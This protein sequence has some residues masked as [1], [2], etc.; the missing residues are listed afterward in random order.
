MW[1]SYDKLPV[2]IRGQLFLCEKVVNMIFAIVHFL[3]LFITVALN[4]EKAWSSES[5][6]TV[7]TDSLETS[8]ISRIMVTLNLQ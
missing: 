7:L 1:G 6:L 5:A 8:I 2:N 4:N 3:I